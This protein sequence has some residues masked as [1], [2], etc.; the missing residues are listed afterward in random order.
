MSRGIL[1]VIGGPMFSGKTTE[2]IRQIKRD[3]IAGY[4]IESFKPKLDNRYTAEKICTNDGSSIESIVVAESGD[5][6]KRYLRTEPQ[7]IFIDE[8]QF[9]EDN[10]T[11]VIEFL[12]RCGVDVT[13]AGLITDFKG[14]SFG[15]MGKLIS[16]AQKVITLSAVCT[17]KDE[18]G[19]IC[20]KPAYFTQRFVNGIPARKSDPVVVVGGS[21]SYSARCEDHWVI[22]N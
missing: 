9:F 17:H 16:I 7:K 11:T 10:I 1:T 2:L 19:I 18:R 20:G 12:L 4:K 13:V 14:D 8:I 22:D 6:T 21:D 5:I 3:T 15:P